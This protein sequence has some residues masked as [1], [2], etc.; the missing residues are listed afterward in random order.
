MKYE[1]IISFVKVLLAIFTAIGVIGGGTA[2]IIK[3][4]SPLIDTVKK[5]EF[6]AL[7]KRV[8]LVESRFKGEETRITHVEDFDKVL[9][10]ALFAILVHELTGN[11]VDKLNKAKSALQDYIINET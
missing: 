8:E 2:I 9:C 4:I 11:S 5:S 1:E 7:E 6:K 3:V 10:K